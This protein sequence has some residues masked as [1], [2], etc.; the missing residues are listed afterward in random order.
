MDFCPNC[1]SRLFPKTISSGDQAL[2]ILVC[3][4]CGYKN[5]E[6]N[7]TS[8][9]EFRAIKHSPKQMVAVIDKEKQLNVEP[10]IRMECPRCG[11]N[12]A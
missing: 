10:T 8:K 9:L 5:K 11:N 12:T 6:A 4:K 7:G 1:G 2:L 3:R